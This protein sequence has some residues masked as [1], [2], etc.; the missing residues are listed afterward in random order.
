MSSKEWR[1]IPRKE[2]LWCPTIDIEKCGGCGA[3]V[4]FCKYDVLEINE[5]NGKAR[6]KNPYNC[7]V[8]CQAC[9]S[10]CPVNA[11]SFPDED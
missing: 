3:C 8:G 9:A 11:I 5:S 1:G 10:L 2:I 7:P 4:E 6:V